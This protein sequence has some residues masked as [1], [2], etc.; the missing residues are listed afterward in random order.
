MRIV[1]GILLFVVAFSA[2]STPNN[3]VPNDI[4]PLPKMQQMVWDLTRADEL[5]TNFVLIDS[6]K[7]KDIETYN[8]YQQVFAI[9]K[10]TKS[11]FYKSYTYYQQHPKLY[12]TLLD[13]VFAIGTRSRDNAAKN[14]QRPQ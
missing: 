7:R 9:H 10:V 1:V 12:K 11:D 3:D 5:V 4:I 13:S 2:C 6:S 14:I 8:M